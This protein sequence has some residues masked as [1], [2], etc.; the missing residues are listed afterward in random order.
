MKLGHLFLHSSMKGHCNGKDL[1]G[2]YRRQLKPKTKQNKN[3]LIMLEEPSLEN[4]NLEQNAEKE[5]GNI[6]AFLFVCL[7]GC[8]CF[9]L[10]CQDICFI[11]FPVKFSFF[12]FSVHRVEDCQLTTAQ[13]IDL[14]LP[15]G[16]SFQEREFDRHNSDLLIYP[17]N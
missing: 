17:F 3:T 9:S 12:S 14:L 16:C 6:P 7:F 5:Q 8:C 11:F 2:I 15:K 4:K 1:G 10:L 13:M